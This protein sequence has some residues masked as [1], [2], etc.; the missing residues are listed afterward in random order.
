[1][2]KGPELMSFT[3]ILAH[4]LTSDPTFAPA[5]ASSTCLQLTPLSSHLVTSN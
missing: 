3:L 5:L 2:S 1:M 4:D